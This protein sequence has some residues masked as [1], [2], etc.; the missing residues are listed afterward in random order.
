MAEAFLRRVAGEVIEVA[1][2]GSNPAGFIVPGAVETM[3][4]I[5]IDIRGGE[6]Q[7]M[8]AYLDRDVAVVITVCGRADQACPTYPGQLQ[9]YHWPFEDPIHAT[10]SPDEVREA[11]RRTRDELERVFTAYGRGWVDAVAAAG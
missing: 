7:H 2:A 5:G 11:F 1:S 4:E 6:S 3:A 9:R 10:G 8:N